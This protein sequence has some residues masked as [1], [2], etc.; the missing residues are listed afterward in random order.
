MTT[1][2]YF[3]NGESSLYDNT[4]LSKFR[5]VSRK[6][7]VSLSDEDLQPKRARKEIEPGKVRLA[8]VFEGEITPMLRKRKRKKNSNPQNMY[9][10]QET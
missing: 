5:P 3:P 6:F 7:R 2:Q 8:S 9:E 1:H 4:T 10:R